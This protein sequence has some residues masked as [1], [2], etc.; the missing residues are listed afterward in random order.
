MCKNLLLAALSKQIK[1]NAPILAH[2]KCHKN[3]HF[4]VHVDGKKRIIYLSCSACDRLIS[5]IKLNGRINKGLSME[6]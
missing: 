6:E 3:A 1:I 2:P 4:D 5:V